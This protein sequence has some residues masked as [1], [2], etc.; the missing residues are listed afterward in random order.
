MSVAVSRPSVSERL[1]LRP[2]FGYIERNR[3]CGKRRDRWRVFSATRFGVRRGFDCFHEFLPFMVITRGVGLLGY[4]RIRSGEPS[5]TAQIGGLHLVSPCGQR[6]RRNASGRLPSGTVIN[7]AYS[8]DGRLPKGAAEGY[9]R[10]R[11][12]AERQQSKSNPNEARDRL[13]KTATRV[14]AANRPLVEEELKRTEATR[15]PLRR[16]SSQIIVGS[17]GN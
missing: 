6:L 14:L 17:R 12:P 9:R 1:I 5:R 13:H 11:G 15:E 8:A 3:G 10:Y 4:S 2:A 7:R 16:T